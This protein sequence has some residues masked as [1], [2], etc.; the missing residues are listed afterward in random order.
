MPRS[1]NWGPKRLSTS[2]LL[3]RRQK[4]S[5]QRQ[6]MMMWTFYLTAC[7]H[8]GEFKSFFL[9]PLSSSRSFIRSIPSLF[10]PEPSPPSAQYLSLL[11]CSTN[12]LSFVSRSI[13]L[14]SS[15]WVN[16]NLNPSY[17]NCSFTCCQ[18]YLRGVLVCLPSRKASTGALASMMM[19]SISL[20]S[21][22]LDWK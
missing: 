3:C 20:P 19:F 1:F 12:L 13:F 6:E 22:F 17:M 14:S 10:F 9:Q 8:I 4:N 18:S 16:L 7:L 21:N 2:F 15:C 11:V 5:S